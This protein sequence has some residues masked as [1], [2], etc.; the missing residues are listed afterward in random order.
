LKGSP[1]GA[2]AISSRPEPATPPCPICGG[3][4]YLRA[5]VPVDDP[6]FGTPVPCQCKE[7]ELR[8]K[9]MAALL[10][11]SKMGGLREQTFERFFVDEKQRKA[12]TRACAF[13]ENPD[14]WLIL[15]GDYGTGKTHLAAAIVNYRL[16]RGEPG[17]FIVVPDLL[18]HLRNTFSPSNDVSYDELFEGVRTAELLVLDDLGTQQTTAWAQEKLFQILNHRYNHRLSTVITTNRSLDDIGGPLASRMA[19]P[20]IS[21]TIL[22]QAADYRGG[23]RAAAP[24]AEYRARRARPRMGTPDNQGIG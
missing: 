17:L 24:P 20:H 9:R 5:D 2:T 1:A 21:T 10:E 8:D 19:D 6:R 16:D 3:K 18:D 22:I 14:G 4:G 12:Y 23:N 13:A 11:R 15:M 7:R